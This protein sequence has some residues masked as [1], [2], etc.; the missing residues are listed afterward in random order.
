MELSACCVV[1]VIVLTFFSSTDNLRNDDFTQHQ[2][3]RVP[4]DGVCDFLF[5]GLVV[6]APAERTAD[7]SSI[8]LQFVRQRLPIQPKHTKKH[9]NLNR[10]LSCWFSHRHC[11]FFALLFCHAA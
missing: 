3:T 9:F 1:L 7:R 10:V 5:G 6:S 8:K 2:L 11:E 4:A